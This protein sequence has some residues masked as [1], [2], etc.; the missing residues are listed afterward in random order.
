MKKML[1]EILEREIERKKEELIEKYPEE[2]IKGYD[3]DY[4][5]IGVGSA[6]IREDPIFYEKKLA[7]KAKE[8]LIDEFKEQDMFFETLIYDEKI[9]AEFAKILKRL[10]KGL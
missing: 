5:D 6:C 9:M 8:A 3:R 10:M 7:R 4:V 2:Y 1:I